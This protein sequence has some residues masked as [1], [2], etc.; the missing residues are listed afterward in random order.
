MRPLEMELCGWGPYREKQKIDFEKLSERGLFLITG[1]TGAGKT[2]VFDALTYALFGDLSGSL[3]EKNSVRSDFADAEI[4]TY[5]E[6]V[7]RHRGEVYRIRRSPEYM[8]PK[9]RKTGDDSYVKEKETAVLTMPNNEKIA[10]S[11]AATRKI[12][13]ILGMDIRQ[14]RQISMIAQ[15]EFARLL[16]ASPKE[17]TQIFREI[18]DTA[19]FERFA[20]LLR[21]RAQ[22]L[23]REMQMYGHKIAE[24]IDSFDGGD[25]EWD[26]LTGSDNPSP[27]AVCAYLEARE[28]LEREKKKTLGEAL[29]E[30]EQ[31]MERISE[32]LKE[33]SL[34]VRAQAEV[35]RLRRQ[36]ERNAPV[37]EK[38]AELEKWM[39]LAAEKKERAD[40]WKAAAKA[41]ED[42]DRA[43]KALQNVYLQAQAQAQEKRTAYEEAN[44]A[45]RNAVIG[46]AASMVEEGKPCPVCG[47]LHHPQIANQD[48]GVPDEAA[49]A[50]LQKEREIAERRMTD[51]YGAAVAQKKE[52][53]HRRE[54]LREREKALAE[55]REQ[56]AG[57]AQ[58]CGE[59]A[60]G[61]LTGQDG[62]E[63][64]MRSLDTDASGGAAG[65]A[66]N[67]QG[68]AMADEHAAMSGIRP[69]PEKEW[70]AGE[71]HRIRERFEEA[72]SGYR[73]AQTL[74]AVKEKEVRGSLKKLHIDT[75]EQ[76]DVR[77]GEL[78]A[79]RGGLLQ[80]KKR[81]TEEQ[82][83]NY[84]LLQNAGRIRRSLEDKLGRMKSL[85]ETYGIVKDLDN[86]T[87]GNNAKR[88]VFEQYVLAGY[89]EEILHAANRRLEQMTSGR[90]AL[91]RAREVGDGRSKDNLEIRVLDQY[92]GRYR[93]VKT[94][95]GGE[96]FKA[97]LSLALGLSDVIQR[98]SGGITVD[99]LF[100]DEGFGA[101]D[102]E[103][104]EQACRTLK[105]LVS[106]NSMIG[107]ISHVPQL[108]EQIENRLV[109]KRTNHGSRC[110]MG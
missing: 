93:S 54:I 56:Y 95:S 77:A 36:I 13:E 57:L 89:F 9:K 28:R 12:Q 66:Q 60:L 49:L 47:S 1:D 80:E 100:I 30:T 16:T 70:T 41:A 88:L 92:T 74:L 31:K 71:L 59:V 25:R 72:V 22:E 7:M 33:A 58:A 109:V 38:R 82:K 39:L 8:R 15:G 32:S 26:A 42:A 105:T 11:S 24:D 84:A 73:E 78:T 90:Y 50:A 35:K 55:S 106:G 83:R 62:A 45:Y 69:V 96:M 94:L 79:Q 43:L 76:A 68:G 19:F 46:I 64:N 63:W 53:E 4:P 37:Y 103:S 29:R 52:S 108:K 18:F 3:R 104:L 5:V 61:S 102:D 17:K 23:Y 65:N 27:E 34:L 81:L 86:L 99:C 110:E 6:L 101:L 10:G 14:F 48:A 21:A 91:H 20:A 98:R 107:I 75:P 97:S 51:A 67:T 85:G 2:T 40:A 44:A 87:S